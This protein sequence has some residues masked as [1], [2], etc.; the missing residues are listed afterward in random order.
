LH[1]RSW[2]IRSTGHQQ[3]TF[4]DATGTCLGST[5]RHGPPHDVTKRRDRD[6]SR[7]DRPADPSQFWP[8]D[9]DTPRPIGR[10][11]RLSTY[12]VDVLLAALLDAG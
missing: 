3:F 2:Q 8:R 11:E 4:H 9:P 12:G 10:G 5:S 7:H 1:S 6:R